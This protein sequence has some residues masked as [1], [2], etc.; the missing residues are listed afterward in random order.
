VNIDVRAGVNVNISIWSNR[1][2]LV[3]YTVEV[4]QVDGVVVGILE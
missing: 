1:K 4:V 2:L 3:G